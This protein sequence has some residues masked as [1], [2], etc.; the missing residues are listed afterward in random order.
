M[1]R[2]VHKRPRLR[3][4]GLV[5]DTTTS[6]DL[7]AYEP[8]VTLE[9]GGKG[10][11]LWDQMATDTPF[12]WTEADIPTVGVL[13]AYT[14]TVVDVLDGDGSPAGK[15][16]VIKEWRSLADQLGMTPTARSRLKLTEA[17]A[18]TAAKRA[19][20]LGSDANEPATIDIDE[21]V[22]E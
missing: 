6:V 1:P 9:P 20:R 17:Q 4:K 15:A 7:T 11:K 16:A 13:C 14:D 2:N 5:V 19:E 21:L 10:E 22:D 3:S 8:L 12:W 18:V